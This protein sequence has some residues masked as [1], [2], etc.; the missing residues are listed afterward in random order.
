[1]LYSIPSSSA[2]PGIV[3][4]Y[5]IACL[6]FRKKQK[7]GEMPDGIQGNLLSFDIITMSLRHR[8]WLCSTQA[9][10]NFVVGVGKDRSCNGRPN[11]CAKLGS[12]RPLKALLMAQVEDYI[13]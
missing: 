3:P 11:F 10:C 2:L 9:S 6:V 12:I 8:S 13:L 4:L 7:S 5:A 1:M